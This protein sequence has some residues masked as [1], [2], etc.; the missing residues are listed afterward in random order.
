[1]ERPPENQS[2]KCIFE[3]QQ[4]VLCFGKIGKESNTFN[5]AVQQYQGQVS[6]RHVTV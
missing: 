3:V 6:G 4:K 5:E 1:M 2:K